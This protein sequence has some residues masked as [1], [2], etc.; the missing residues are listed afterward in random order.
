MPE[1]PSNISTLQTL[2]QP[3]NPIFGECHNL[4]IHPP[5]NPPF[6]GVLEVGEWSLLS[7]TTT[8]QRKSL[9]HSRNS[10]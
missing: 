3:S 4:T 6:R 2:Q 8:L 9:L 5:N 7:L 1:I 10:P